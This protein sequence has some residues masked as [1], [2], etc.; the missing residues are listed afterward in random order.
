MFYYDNAF[1]CITARYD[2]TPWPNFET[3]IRTLGLDASHMEF[4]PC[5]CMDEP[6]W[7]NLLDTLR[8]LHA[9]DRCR[10][11][12]L[13]WVPEDLAERQADGYGLCGWRDTALLLAEIFHIAQQFQGSGFWEYLERVLHRGAATSG[14]AG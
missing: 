12:R 9:W 11:P 6:N 5:L 8:Y 2:M 3:M 14:Y 4:K 1:R 7:V 10:A 13:F